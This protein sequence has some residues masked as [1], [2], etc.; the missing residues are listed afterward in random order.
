[1]EHIGIILMGWTLGLILYVFAFYV[2]YTCIFKKNQLEG[3]TQVEMKIPPS[4][5]ERLQQ[6]ISLYILEYVN[7]M[8]S[9]NEIEEPAKKLDEQMVRAEFKLTKQEFKNAL[10]T[11]DTF[12]VMYKKFR[13]DAAAKKLLT[14]KIEDV[15]LMSGYSSLESFRNAFK[16]HHG[17][18]PGEFQKRKKLLY[19]K[20]YQVDP[21]IKV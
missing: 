20:H 15:Q 19:K 11:G 14:H 2:I 9:V 7:Q 13:F 21:P 4:S 6:K 12:S 16:R 5:D 3:L 17:K 18:N 10:S 8:F 1:M